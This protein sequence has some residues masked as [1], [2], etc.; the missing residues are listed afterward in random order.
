MRN[1]I[2]KWII[3]VLAVLLAMMPAAAEET[4][5]AP[6]ENEYY[7]D[8][9]LKTEYLAFDAAG[10]P[11]EIVHHTDGPGRFSLMRYS[12]T[13]DRAGNVLT[14]RITLSDGSFWQFY[15]N[16]YGRDGNLIQRTMYEREDG[17]PS[18]VTAYETDAD[19]N[20]SRRTTYK[21]SSGETTESE[22]VSGR[23]SREIVRD[24]SGNVQYT[25]EVSYDDRGRIAEYKTVIP[26]G[27]TYAQRMEYDGQDRTVRNR[28][29]VDEELLHDT[30]FEYT[31]TGWI[32][33]D[34]GYADYL[35][36]LSV[37]EYDRY[38][39]PLRRT[40]YDRDGNVTGS[41]AMEYDEDGNRTGQTSLD[42]DGNET[43][44]TAVEYDGRGT[45][46]RETTDFPDG[47]RTV[48]SFDGDGNYIRNRKINA[49]G[50]IRQETEY[51]TAGDV[52]IRDYD[53]EGN[54]LSE[55][56]W[57]ARGNVT[58]ESGFENGIMVYSVEKEYDENGNVTETVTMEYD[59]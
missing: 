52:L 8:G 56:V 30:E 57:D 59:P 11:T 45:R 12:V 10:N 19:G 53:A 9:S 43:S 16:E 4:K 29:Y 21:Y 24:A 33:R 35:P 18:S 2:G 34:T 44:R 39:L 17:E 13:Y 14:E 40:D 47:S 42:A 26:P 1:G 50:I 46:I 51:G 15:E 25:S 20:V 37:T 6:L 55:T 41:T 28:M 54:V 7:E 36:A 48:A 31:D 27:R 23:L 58:R 5:T 32:E 38:G 22:Y 3:L 49:D